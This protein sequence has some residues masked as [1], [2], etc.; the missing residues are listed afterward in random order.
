MAASL[1]L[2]HERDSESEQGFESEA[3]SE[4][5]DT[6]HDAETSGP[7]KP[8]RSRKYSGAATYLTKFN[9]SWKKEFPFNTCVTKDPYR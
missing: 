1:M 9:P 3:D 4:E 2:G 5:S 7:P 6:D 8:K